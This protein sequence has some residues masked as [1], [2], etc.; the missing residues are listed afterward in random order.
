MFYYLFLLII[1]PL[2]KVQTLEDLRQH[3][4]HLNDTLNRTVEALLSIQQY[5]GE[6]RKECENLRKEIKKANERFS[7]LQ[8]KILSQKHI[9]KERKKKLFE[10]SDTSTDILLRNTFKNKIQTHQNEE[11]VRIILS[12]L[13][14]Y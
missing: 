5:Q 7:E 12:R 9:E 8:D 2:V 6:Y 4:K 1:L 14:I 3:N 13:T 10:K 11:D